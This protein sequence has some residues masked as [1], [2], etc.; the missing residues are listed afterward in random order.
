[1]RHET[2]DKV[3]G[4]VTMGAICLMAAAPAQAEPSRVPPAPKIL[5]DPAM[6]DQLGK[7]IGALTK[8]V[9]D[10]PV[11]ELEAAIEN[12]PVTGADRN[13]RVRDVTTGGD[14]AVERRVAGPDKPVQQRRDPVAVERPGLLQCVKHQHVQGV[15]QLGAGRRRCFIRHPNRAYATSIRTSTEVL[16]SR[17]RLS[18]LHHGAMKNMSSSMASRP[19]G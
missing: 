13:R 17:A 9:M 5:T 11:G 16:S 14:P 2:K 19:P 6:A 18:W 8:A 15:R 7:M 12:R 4:V 1:M 3:F 10:M